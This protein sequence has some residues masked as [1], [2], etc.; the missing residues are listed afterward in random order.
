MM[1]TYLQVSG[2]QGLRSSSADIWIW[3]PCGQAWLRVV[4]LSSLPL[5]VVDLGSRGQAPL[6]V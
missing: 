3:S 1:I 6:A 5:L 2:R 4:E